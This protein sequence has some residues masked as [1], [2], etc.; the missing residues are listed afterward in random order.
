MSQADVVE[1]HDLAARLNAAAEVG[2]QPAVRAK[3]TPD[4]VAIY[5]NTGQDQI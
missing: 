2:M 1:T 3:L 4:R 5:D